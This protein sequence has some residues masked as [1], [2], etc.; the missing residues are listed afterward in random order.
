LAPDALAAAPDAEAVAE[1]RLVV[2]TLV[3]GG[4]VAMTKEEMGVVEE[5]ISL[6]DVTAGVVEIKGEVV[7]VNTMTEIVGVCEAMAEVTGATVWVTV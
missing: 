4:G 2:G 6:E 5:M 3:T 7:V 1:E